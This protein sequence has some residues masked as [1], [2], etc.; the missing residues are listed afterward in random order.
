MAIGYGE[1]AGIMMAAVLSEQLGGISLADVAR[2]EKLLVQAIT[3]LSPDGMQPEITY[4][5]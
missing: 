3:T 4:R 2:L 1:A 5:T